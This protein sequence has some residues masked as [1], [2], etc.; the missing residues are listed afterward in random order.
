MRVPFQIWGINELTVFGSLAGGRT[1]AMVVQTGV[2]GCGVGAP[3]EVF[4][5]I[6]V[7]PG[8]VSRLAKGAGSFLQGRS[9]TRVVV[10]TVAVGPIVEDKVDGWRGALDS[11]EL[12]RH[13]VRRDALLSSE[14]FHD[15]R[16]TFDW[17]AREL[18]VEE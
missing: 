9:W 3:T 10:P 4:D 8:V 15:R 7:K 11:S 6:G 5:E 18:A 13:G 17:G 1:M 16:V 12:W 2:P 14:F